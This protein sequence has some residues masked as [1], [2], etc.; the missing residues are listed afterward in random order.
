MATPDEPTEDITPAAGW[1]KLEKCLKKISTIRGPR[2][3]RCKLLVAY[4]KPLWNW[5]SPVFALPPMETVKNTMKALIRSHCRWWCKGRFWAQHIGLHPRYS[6]IFTAVERITNWDIQ[7]SSFLEHNFKNFF[8]ELGLEFVEY[9]SD[10]G[11]RFRR[12]AEE[13]DENVSRAFGR[14]C[15][16]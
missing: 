16:L 11:V 15:F 14:G 13:A 4:A 1:L 6:A 12:S 9:K 2:E 10:K 5:C 3:T 7:W 8:K